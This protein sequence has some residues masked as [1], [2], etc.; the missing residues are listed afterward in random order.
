MILSDEVVNSFCFDLFGGGEIGLVPDYDD[1]C[2]GL[3]IVVDFLEPLFEV[4]EGLG[5][6]EI[7]DDDGAHC[8][9]VVCSCDGSEP[10]LPGSIP[11]LVLDDF[12]VDGESFGEELHADSGLCV[13][14]EGVADVLGEQ[15]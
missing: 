15:V 5:L 1:G 12:A 6:G 7:E 3:S 9:A 4:L 10:F 13:L 11:Y 8:A 2:T 14:V